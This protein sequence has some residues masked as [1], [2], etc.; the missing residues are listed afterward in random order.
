VLAVLPILVA[1]KPLGAENVERRDTKKSWAD[2]PQVHI[3]RATRRRFVSVAS[4][5]QALSSSHLTCGFMRVSQ[6]VDLSPVAVL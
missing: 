3:L 4:E 2:G 1:S 5:V 6:R